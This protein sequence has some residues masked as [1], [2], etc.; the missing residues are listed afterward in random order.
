MFC[1]S[2]VNR[3]KTKKPFELDVGVNNPLAAEVARP[4]RF[5]D[6]LTVTA[7]GQSQGTK[8][9]RCLTTVVDPKQTDRNLI[10]EEIHDLLKMLNVSSFGVHRGRVT[11][12]RI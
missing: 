3:K 8:K 1:E 11:R 5:S 12:E 9:A 4:V 2:V 7:A 6:T 10:T